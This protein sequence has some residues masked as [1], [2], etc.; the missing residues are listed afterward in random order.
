MDKRSQLIQKYKVLGRSKLLN[1][2]DKWVANEVVNS[3][4]S[5]GATLEEMAQGY[6]KKAQDFMTLGEV[7]KYLQS[8][9]VAHIL[10]S[11]AK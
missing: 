9:S 6:M 5:E 4:N 1:E 8:H 2:K 11:I 7:G 10:L 3:L